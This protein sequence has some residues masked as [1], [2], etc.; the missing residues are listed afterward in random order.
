MYLSTTAILGRL[1]W[2]CICHKFRSKCIWVLEYSSPVCMH[3]IPN[4]AKF[5]SD[6][7]R[8]VLAAWD[9]MTCISIHIS[10]FEARSRLGGLAVAHSILE[11]ARIAGNMELGLGF[12]PSRQG[13]APLWT[14]LGYTEYR[15]SDWIGIIN[16]DDASF[17]ISLDRGW[18]RNQ[19]LRN[20]WRLWASE[21]SDLVR[22][23]WSCTKRRS[24]WPI[25]NGWV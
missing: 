1:F 4:C 12:H 11:S 15:T 23:S 20:W 7:T 24:R 21:I 17:S 19:I 6:P 14:G 10:Q 16:L 2:L 5:L 8:I 9:K 25:K 13:F 3:N 18:K 22:G